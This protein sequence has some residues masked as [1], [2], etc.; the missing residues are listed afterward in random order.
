MTVI[1]GCSFLFE[2][3]AAADVFTR[4]DISEEQ[5]MFARIAEEFMRT[6]VLPR[7]RTDL[8]QGLAVTRELLLKR[9]NWTC[10]A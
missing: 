9:A 8:R 1:R 3:R 10:C 5:Q 2:D 6:E 7:A 4:E